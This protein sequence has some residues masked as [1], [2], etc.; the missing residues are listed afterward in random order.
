[1]VRARRRNR[2]RRRWPAC[3][4]ELSVRTELPAVATR[5]SCRRVLLPPC[6]SI[7]R[8]GLAAAETDGH[9]EP[10]DTLV[11]VRVPMTRRPLS[12]ARF[13]MKR[14]A[15]CEGLRHSRAI[16]GCLRWRAAV[17]TGAWGFDRRSRRV[18]HRKAAAGPVLHLCPSV[19]RGPLERLPA[20]LVSVRSQCR[21]RA[22][23]RPAGRSGGF[24]H[25]RAS[26]DGRG[27]GSAGTGD[28]ARWVPAGTSLWT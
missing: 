21:G 28:A 7:H 18:S 5:R 13:W 9:D 20:S 17:A 3:G 25:G 12:R 6:C 15:G 16:P 27:R 24:R 26:R 22:P 2:L 4:G 1:M 10:H 8:T 19:E 11:T 23:D 14:L